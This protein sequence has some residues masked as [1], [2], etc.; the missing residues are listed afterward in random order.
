MKAGRLR[1]TIAIERRVESRGD[2]GEVLAAWEQVV[3]NLPADVKPL[4]ADRIRAAQ[5]VQDGTTVEVLIRYR[6]D[7]AGTCRMRYR[8]AVYPLTGDPLADN[9][10]GQE[11]MTLRAQTGIE[12]GHEGVYVPLEFSLNGQP[13]NL[14]PDGSSMDFA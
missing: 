5:A 9:R 7:I 11:W 1:H 10:S 14:Q 8:G 2:T 3:D 6:T 13:L 12:V 4:S